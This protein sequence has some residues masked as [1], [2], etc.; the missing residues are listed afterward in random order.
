MDEAFV[1][2]CGQGSLSEGFCSIMGLD[3]DGDGAGW[4]GTS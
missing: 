1:T 2:F 3:R 4:V